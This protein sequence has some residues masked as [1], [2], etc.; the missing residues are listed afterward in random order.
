MT[1]YKRLD[2]E[3][4]D[5][6]IYRVCQDKELIGTWNDVKDILN[7]LLNADYGESALTW[8][9]SAIRRSIRSRRISSRRRT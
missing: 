4:D 7:E 8:W 9:L 2:G 3:S 1:K 5:E 6:L